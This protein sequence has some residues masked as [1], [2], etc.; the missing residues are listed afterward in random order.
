MPDQKVLVDLCTM[1]MPFGRYEGRVLKDLPETYVVWFY[2]KGFP[3]GRLGV[4][5]AS[6]YEIKLNGLEFLLHEMARRI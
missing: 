2:Q 5:L 1:K 6:L 4:L 3:Q